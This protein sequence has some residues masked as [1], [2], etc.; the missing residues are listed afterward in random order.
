ILLFAALVWTVV[1][2]II[3]HRLAVDDGQG[4][5]SARE[6][7]LLS[8]FRNATLIVIVTMTILIV[9]SQIGIDIGP[10]IAG[11]G[12]VGLAIGFGAQKL[13]QE[14]I[15]GIF[16][17]LENG[18]NQNDV[19][20]I[21]NVFGTVEKITIRSVGIRT[22]D[23]GYHMIPFSSVDKFAN[24]MRDFSYHLG[25][26]TIAYRESVDEAAYYLERAF[27]EL[28][29]DPVLAPEVLEDMVISGVTSLNERGF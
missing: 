15:N 26:Y 11:G 12:V 14:V 20:Q 25:E 27:D 17:Q 5:P 3:E 8:L 23:G 10:L 19:V 16:I 7:T 2:S 4:A 13:V 29:T 6:R 24:H 18:M 22:L 9:L 1:A 28:M 21:G